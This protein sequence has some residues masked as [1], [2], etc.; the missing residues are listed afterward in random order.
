MVTHQRRELFNNEVVVELLRDAFR[1]VVKKY[2][3]II[4]AMVVL[5][6]HLHSI[7]TLPQGDADYMTR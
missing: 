4:E 5:P 2:P 1:Q 7:W 3:F 6:D